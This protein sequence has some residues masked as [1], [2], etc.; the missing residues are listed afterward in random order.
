MGVGVRSP[1]LGPDVN[2]A[3]RP[4]PKDHG[5]L[6]LSIAA[7]GTLSGTLYGVSTL[8]S[9]GTDRLESQILFSIQDL[10]L[11]IQIKSKKWNSWVLISLYKS[12]VN[13]DIC[14]QIILLF[15]QGCEN[16]L[17]TS[18]CEE[19]FRRTRRPVRDNLVQFIRDES[20]QV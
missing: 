10:Q 6:G 7:R 8:M 18:F 9:K 15:L 19:L 2:A 14:H 5:Q 13:N 4:I 3:L 20:S 11:L 12:R 17:R 1:A 16:R